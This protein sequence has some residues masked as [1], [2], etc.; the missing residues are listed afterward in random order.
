ML[1]KAVERRFEDPRLRT[2][3]F[4]HAVQGGH[5]PR[6]VPAWFGILDYLEQN[7]GTWTVPGGLGALA[8]LL[9]K[10]LG[11]RRVEVLTGVTALDLVMSATASDAHPVAVST[12]AGEIAGD[13]VVVATDP[14]STCPPSR[15]TSSA[16][17]RPSRRP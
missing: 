6:N 5:D 13:Q 12:T 11:E 8:A 10:R 7:F 4:H 3:A 1:H 2:L 16:A 9:T 14:R 17:C 15:R